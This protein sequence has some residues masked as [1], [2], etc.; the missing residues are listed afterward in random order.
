MA[1]PKERF[2]TTLDSK[3]IA[4]LLA[5]AMFDATADAALLQFMHELGA[6][7][8][9]EDSAARNWKR[10]GAMRMMEILKSIAKLPEA[11]PEPISSTLK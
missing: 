4:P 6:A 10:E 11:P 7:D 9:T 3:S 1:N 5:S 8:F 2:L